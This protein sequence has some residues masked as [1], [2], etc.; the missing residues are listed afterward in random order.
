MK[1]F[2]WQFVEFLV[3]DF[4]SCF[5]MVGAKLLVFLNHFYHT[6]SYHKPIKQLV[7]NA[8]EV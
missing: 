2:N 8:R 7:K 4:N 1:G 5:F 3:H 6:E